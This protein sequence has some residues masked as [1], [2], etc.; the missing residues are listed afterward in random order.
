MPNWSRS[1]FNV[2]NQLKGVK[3][4]LTMKY[5]SSSLGKGTG[6]GLGGKMIYGN[7][8]NIDALKKKKLI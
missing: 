1:R 3:G 8:K 7:Q 2:L 5:K 6:M 4:L